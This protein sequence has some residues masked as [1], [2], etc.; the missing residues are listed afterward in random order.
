MHFHAPSQILFLE[1]SC[2]CWEYFALLCFQTQNMIVIW[3][4]H[5]GCDDGDDALL[6][7][8]HLP[9]HLLGQSLRLLGLTLRMLKRKSLEVGHPLQP[10]LGQI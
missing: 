4:N 2:S 1:L 7:H 5:C 9:L 6:L 8:L 10:V 3:A